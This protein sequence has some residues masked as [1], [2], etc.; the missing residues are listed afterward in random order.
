MFADNDT[1]MVSTLSGCAVLQHLAIVVR[2]GPPACHC[3][4]TC[5]HCTASITYFTHLRARNIQVTVCAA[6]QE[7]KHSAAYEATAAEEEPE[8]FKSD[9]FRI[10]C[11]KVRT[12]VVLGRRAC[13]KQA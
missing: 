13:P 9:D 7:R 2:L 4:F 11:M 5:R 8:L 6:A 1:A 3:G 12:P 10:F